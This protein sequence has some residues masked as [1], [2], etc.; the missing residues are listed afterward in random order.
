M[1]ASIP[2]S[3]AASRNAVSAES[4][5][6]AISVHSKK[7]RRPVTRAYSRQASINSSSGHRRLTGTSAARSSS[8]APWRLTASAYGR[9]SRASRRMPGATPTVLIVIRAGPILIPR[10]SVMI[11]SAAITA[12]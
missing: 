8:L 9:C 10:R 1:C 5:R 6:P 4:F 12:S 7:I 3:S 11:S 2:R